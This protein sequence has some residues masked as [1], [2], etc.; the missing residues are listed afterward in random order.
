MCDQ[1]SLRSACAYAQSDQSLCKSLEYSMIVKLLTE[2]HLEFLSL[3]GGCRGSSES[4]LVKTPH[5]WKSHALALIYSPGTELYHI[6]NR[7]DYL[8]RVFVFHKVAN[9]IF[10]ILA[11]LN[12]LSE[13]CP[14]PKYMHRQVFEYEHT[15]NN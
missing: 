5:C 3:K 2:H 11:H 12:L 10:T 14:R 4:T 6:C 13:S 1:Q 15:K 9:Q 7:I 8:I